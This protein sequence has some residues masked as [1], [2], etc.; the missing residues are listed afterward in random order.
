MSD[1]PALRLLVTGAAGQLGVDLVRLAEAAGV[2]VTGATS[3]ELDIT[4][5]A[6]VDAAAA[7]LA[8]AAAGSGARGVIVNCAAYTAVD[9]AETD[10]ER[11]YAVNRT[12]PENLAKAAAAAGLGLIH[13]STDYVFPGDADTPYTPDDATG[14]KGVY[15]ASKLAGEQAVLA[16]DPDAH[17]IRTAWVYGAGGKNFVK[18]MVR[19]SETHPQITVVA[20]QVG[21]P[22][23]T[24]D[25]ATGLLE[26]AR[27]D[28]AGT[29]PGG[30]LHATGG[31]QTSWHGFAQAIFA[32]V[33]ADPERVRPISTADYPTPA[34]RPAYSVLSPDA[35]AAAG[36]T[37]LRGWREA[38][39]EAFAQDGPAYRPQRP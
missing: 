29:V 7:E 3:A 24:V 10:S 15:G 33:G 32:E 21:S 12:G 1:S 6:A 25:L 34:A 9:A 30:V 22:T 11:A 2:P 18:T 27:A 4:D 36:L 8:A 13:V 31:G 19:L 23:W 14:P 20:D 16:A 38:L 26:L 35:W 37:P 39:T 5:A 28:A 17:V